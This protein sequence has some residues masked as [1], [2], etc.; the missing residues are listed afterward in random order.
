MHDPGTPGATAP[1]PA[2]RLECRH[3]AWHSLGI[4]VVVFG[5]A[6][7]LTQAVA[8]GLALLTI[9]AD[10]PLQPDGSVAYYFGVGI[11]LS[12]Q[13]ATNIGWLAS[14]FTPALAGFLL[15][16]SVF[17]KTAIV[18]ARGDAAHRVRAELDVQAPTRR[19]A[20]PIALAAAGTLCTL[21]GALAYY[22]P[23]CVGAVAQTT[24]GRVPAGAGDA[25]KTLAITAA[26]DRAALAR[27]AAIPGI[28]I[29]ASVAVYIT[30]WLGLQ[31]VVGLPPPTTPAEVA[32]RETIEGAAVL[33]WLGAVAAL[34]V[35]AVVA[36]WFLTRYA[37]SQL[38]VRGEDGSDGQLVIEATGTPGYLAKWTAICLVTGGAGLLVYP[39][40][41]LA[42][43]LNH[44]N[45][46][47]VFAPRTAEGQGK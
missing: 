42:R 28:A 5:A 8:I 47:G 3:S 2:Y 29:A 11:G 33:R 32:A 35:V 25:A 20:R 34:V 41:A 44:T 13:Y 4:C 22:L 27:Q 24:T 9:P 31:E 21:G 1:G 19:F 45:A 43:A 26:L 38:Q 10:F 7:I 40:K 17:R 46:A 14:A 36:A 18:A 39:A 12:R 30:A 6:G 15:I 37:I 16:R 23:W